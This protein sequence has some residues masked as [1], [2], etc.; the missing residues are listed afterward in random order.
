MQ[1]V[2][3][4]IQ[5]AKVV[6]DTD[7][8]GNASVESG[9]IFGEV[10]KIEYDRGD[11]NAGTVAV[12][13]NT[14]TTEQLDSKDVNAAAKAVSYPVAARSGANAG[15]NKW[16]NH[17]VIGTLTVTVNGGAANKTFSIFIHYK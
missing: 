12:I 15:D 4:K 7:G 6:V 5:T 10:L 13:T 16:T 3:A 2:I 11:V 17:I 9:K 14:F 1:Y 8:A